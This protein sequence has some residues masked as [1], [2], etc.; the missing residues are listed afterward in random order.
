LL[1]DVDNN[2]NSSFLMIP[3]MIGRTDQIHRLWS[4]SSYCRGEAHL[5][6]VLMNSVYH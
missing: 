5:I 4:L 6:R 2:E 1:D 3:N